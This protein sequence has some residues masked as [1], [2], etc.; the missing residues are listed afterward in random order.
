MMKFIQSSAEVIPMND[1]L[2]HIEKIGR[3]CYKS[4][5][6]LTPETAEKFFNGLVK[7]GHHSVLEHATFIFEDITNIPCITSSVFKKKYLNCTQVGFLSGDGKHTTRI[8]VSGNLRAI[9]E[10]GVVS[11]M[12]CLEKAYPQLSGY[13][14]L[15]KDSNEYDEE[16]HCPSFKLLSR[17][18]FLELSPTKKEVSKHLYTT[19]SFITD[20]GVT[21]EMVRHRP[22]SY[23]QESTRYCN[24]SKDKFENQI[25]FI[26]PATFDEWNEAQKYSYTKLLES[27]EMTYLLLTKQ[28]LKPQ[29]ARGVLPV[30]TKAQ[31]VMTANDEE[32]KHFF[33]L[34][35]RGTTGSPHPNMKRVADIALQKYKEYNKI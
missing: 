1:P 25:E 27:A 14:N 10:S 24:Y 7:S 16:V 4:N 6:E 19:I 30:D 33:N 20:R 21:H 29:F 5:S 12:V 35:S 3:V 11:L 2:I 34:R 32:W 8:L 18:E 15:D 28:G 31:I 17:E 9:K 23:S 26:T 22:A 13:F